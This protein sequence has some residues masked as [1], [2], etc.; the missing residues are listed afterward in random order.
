MVFGHA[1]IPLKY[2]LALREIQ[3]KALDATY[4]IENQELKHSMRQETY[5]RKSQKKYDDQKLEKI[6]LSDTE[7]PELHRGDLEQSW[8]REVVLKDWITLKSKTNCSQCK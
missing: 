5:M 8:K 7:R 2:P 1:W 4:V 6:D 3:H